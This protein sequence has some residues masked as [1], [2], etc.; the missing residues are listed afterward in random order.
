MR[1]TGDGGGQ[2]WAAAVP[3]GI[4]RREQWQLLP[5]HGEWGE[6]IQVPWGSATKNRPAGENEKNWL[7]DIR[8]GEFIEHELRGFA[9]SP[10]NL[11]MCAC[12]RIRVRVR[13][14]WCTAKSFTAV[15]DGRGQIRFGNIQSALMGFWE[16]E[17]KS[18]LMF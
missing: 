10:V 11:Y 13:W 3:S 14:W 8:H 15:A 4:I 6:E 1:G 17:L 5:I 9:K 16:M 18:T 2:G 7:V 12:I